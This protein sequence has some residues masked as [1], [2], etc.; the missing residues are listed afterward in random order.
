MI[1]KGNQAIDN[2]GSRKLYV[3]IGAVKVLKVNPTKAELEEIYDREIENEPEY[4]GTA[5]RG[6]DDN[7]QS[8]PS[9][10]VSFIVATDPEKN[11]GIEL[12]TTHSFF[13]VKNY[14]KSSAGKAKVIDKYGRTAWVTADEFKA[15]AI[16][17]DKN[18]NPINV[19]SD[20]R[21]CWEGEEELT[22]FIKNWLNIP[23]LLVYTNGVWTPNPRVTPADCQVR[24]DTVENMFKGD[25]SEIREAL[26]YQP[27]NLVKIPFGVKNDTDRNRQLQTTYT[28][29]CFKNAVND[30]SKFELEVS[31]RKEA[32]ALSNVEYEATPLHEYVVDPTTLQPTMEQVAAANMAGAETAW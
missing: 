31:Q 17:T 15:K 22:T 4:V 7:K 25:I 13:V 9:I 21:L 18:G 6:D 26:S 5:E 3:G 29:M 28:R 24:L 1:A 23:N 10:R 32:G 11:N 14:V 20:Y 30:Y 27:D 2:G 16:P 8:Y 12:T 19:D